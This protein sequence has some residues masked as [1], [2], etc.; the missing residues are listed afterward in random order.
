MLVVST[1]KKCKQQKNKD[2]EKSMI[3]KSIKELSSI[4]ENRAYLFRFNIR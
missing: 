2:L 4:K 1:D 3:S